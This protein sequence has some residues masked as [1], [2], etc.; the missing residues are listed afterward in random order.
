M[1][2]NSGP[3]P[4]PKEV[5]DQV[6]GVHQ[7]AQGAAKHDAVR[8]PAPLGRQCETSWGYNNQSS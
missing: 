5:Q 1:L 3:G 6:H 8:E 7:E 4:R 2:L